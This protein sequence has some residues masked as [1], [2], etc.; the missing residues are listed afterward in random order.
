MIQR[1]NHL[2]ERPATAICVLS[3]FNAN[4]FAC[5]SWH[6]RSATVPSGIFSNGITLCQS[7]FDR[8]VSMFFIPFQQMCMRLLANIR[9]L[10]KFLT[11]ECMTV[12]VFLL[13]CV[14]QTQFTALM[15]DGF[16]LLFVFSHSLDAVNICC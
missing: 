10:F 13:L 11:T 4:A 16:S 8:S 5:P 3:L 14:R 12:V 7:P 15:C 6:I 1:E 9:R 2:R